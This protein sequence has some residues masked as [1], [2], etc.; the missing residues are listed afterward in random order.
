MTPPDAQHAIVIGASIA[1]LLAARVLTD[2]FERVT[3]IERDQLPAAPAAR[4]GVPQARHA[5]ILLVRGRRILDQL[6]PDLINELVAHGAVLFDT[7]ADLK[8]LT[9]TGWT[10]RVPTGYLTVSCTRDLLEWHVRQRLHQHPRISFLQQT[11]ATSLLADPVGTT[12]TGVRV[13]SR[14]A[15]HAVQELLAE[16][17]VDAS[18][19]GSHAPQWLGELGYPAPPETIVNP[20]L[21]YASRIFAEPTDLKVDWKAVLIQARAPTLMRA[22]AILPIEGR[23]WIVTLAGYGRDYPPND[24]AGYMEF[25]KSLADPFIYDSLRDAKPLTPIN[26]YQRTENHMRHYE[27]LARFPENFFVTGDAVSAF[28]PVYGQGMTN[29]ARGALTLDKALRAGRRGASRAFQVEIAKQN[30]TPW[31]MAIT[32]DYRFP[33]TE[34]AKPGITTRAVQWYISRVIETAVDKPAVFDAFNAVTHLMMPPSVLFS[35]HMLLQVLRHRVAAPAPLPV[36]ERAPVGHA[37]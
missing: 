35:P 16:V 19:R 23:R 22:G 21:G 11:D 12:I 7:T 20:F 8:L 6:F 30:E 25:A 36:S 34:G 17:V 26:G 4:S 9:P 14:A 5:H 29:A 31:L 13:R 24:E 10:P 33:T 32:E 2:H 27:R 18:G 15:N 37:T 28:N 1:G 3:L